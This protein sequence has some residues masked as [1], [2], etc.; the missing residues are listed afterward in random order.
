MS[1]SKVS[2]PVQVDEVRHRVGCQRD[3]ELLVRFGIIQLGIIIFKIVQFR[4]WQLAMA[5]C[6][7]KRDRRARS[8][9]SPA[10]KNATGIKNAAGTK[11][12]VGFSKSRETTGNR[13]CSFFGFQLFLVILTSPRRFWQQWERAHKKK[14]ITHTKHEAKEDTR[15]TSD[16]YNHAL[17][18]CAIK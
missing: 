8:R 18:C 15:Q 14:K 13:D 4:V 9:T 12:A 11:N 10:A 3:V 2:G 5:A 16:Q 7:Q 17:F 1:I 6:N